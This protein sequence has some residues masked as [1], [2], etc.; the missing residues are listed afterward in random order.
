MRA[1]FFFNHHNDPSY[2][3]NNAIF[4]IHN[5]KKNNKV[6]TYKKKHEGEKVRNV[7][8]AKDRGRIRHTGRDARELGTERGG[9]GEQK[10]QRWINGRID[11]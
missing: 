8:R 3:L 5:L 2:S 10:E 4:V 11:R 1:F 6:L 7:G 9:G